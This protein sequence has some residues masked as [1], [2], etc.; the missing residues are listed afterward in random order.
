MSALLLHH[1]ATLEVQELQVVGDHARLALARHLAVRR[2]V[3]EFP[4]P[5][6]LL[7]Q[8]RQHLTP[9]AENG[10]LEA[11]M[12]TTMNANSL[13]KSTLEVLPKSPPRYFA[14]TISVH[15]GG[16][17]ISERGDKSGGGG[18]ILTC[19]LTS[20][21]QKCRAEGCNADRG[22]SW[23]SSTVEERVTSEWMVL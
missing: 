17:D 10:F 9:R 4:A 5:E 12:V 2:R 14:A 16:G 23:Y 13:V 18:N 15:G 22:F 8:L 6:V 20:E 19:N 7:V 21:A 1:V 11:T 3:Q